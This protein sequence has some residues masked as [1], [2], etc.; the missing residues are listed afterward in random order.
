MLFNRVVEVEE[1]M[2]K[3][4]KVEAELIPNGVKIYPN[5]VEASFLDFAGAKVL[6]EADTIEELC[7]LFYLDRGGDVDVND[8][9]D[10]YQLDV[11][12]EYYLEEIRH[13]IPIK[14]QAYI[15]TDKGLI[16]VAKM[17]DKGEL[18]LI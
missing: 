4:I 16:Y 5:N 18:V 12:K 2:K 8:F 7:D 9:Y 13:F 17:N 11:A 1:T 10:K 15:R 3:Y 14:L 6:A